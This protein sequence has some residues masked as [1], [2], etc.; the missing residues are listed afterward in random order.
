MS[1]REQEV[2]DIQWNEAETHDQMSTSNSNT[3]VCLIALSCT[4]SLW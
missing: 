2:V 3:Y 1:G 4:I